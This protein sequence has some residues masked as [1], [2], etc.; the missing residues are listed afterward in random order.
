MTL[1]RRAAVAILVAAAVH[2]SAGARAGAGGWQSDM[3][4]KRVIASGADW[5]PRVIASR[6]LA[7]DRVA[8][9]CGS[10]NR[11][12]SDRPRTYQIDCSQR[13]VYQ[14]G[15]YTGYSMKAIASYLHSHQV[16]FHNLVGF[17]SFNGLPSERPSA[18]STSGSPARAYH[19]RV[20]KGDYRA[21][22]YSSSR[23]FGGEGG[24][25]LASTLR[26]LE[27]HIGEPRVRWV[28]GFYNESLTP[29][30]AASMRPAMLVDCDADLYSS[31]WQSLGWMLE[32]RLITAGTVL[33]YDDWKAGSNGGQALAHAELVKKYKMRARLIKPDHPNAKAVFEVMGV[34]EKDPDRGVGD[35]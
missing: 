19:A 25:D 3:T 18:A 2:A 35:L 14:F 28:P 8:E 17:D 15:V 16:G 33:F 10:N 20:A 1:A 26:Q 24:G 11:T 27:A 4:M 9:V 29:A 13:D 22:L 6:R 5:T 21:G 30:L 31:T 7:L 23:F 32:H 12:S 34:G